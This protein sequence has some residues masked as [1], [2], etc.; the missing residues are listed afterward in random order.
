M[1][2]RTKRQI[3]IHKIQTPTNM[4]PPFT[5][6]PTAKLWLLVLHLHTSHPWPRIATILSRKFAT[7]IS[8]EGAQAMY[9]YYE[10]SGDREFAMV[11]WSRKEDRMIGRV[12]ME[13]ESGLKVRLDVAGEKSWGFDE[14]EGVVGW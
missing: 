13:A 14:Q 3:I 9:E 11:L 7:H 1:K 5:L 8:A 4:P 12:V 10:I 6:P 2:P